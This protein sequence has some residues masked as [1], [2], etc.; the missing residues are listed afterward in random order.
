MSEIFVVY[1]ELEDVDPV[2]WRKLEILA[3]ASF[4]D[5]HCAIQDV[6]PWENRHLH[7][8]RFPT[9]DAETQIGIPDPELEA[10]PDF[11][12]SWETLLEDWFPSLPTSC[13]YIYD[14]GDSWRHRIILQS[15][16]PASDGVEYPR[17]IDGQGAC[18]PEDVGGAHRFQE[19]LEA[20]ADPTHEDHESFL[21]WYGDLWDPDPFDPDSVEFVS[22][23][24]R[25][26][27]LGIG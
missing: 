17:C 12:G 15:K 23:E 6:M 8:F 13:T 11:V 26:L 16:T 21:D 4:W 7:E 19:F 9:G 3:S 1:V 27:T 20:M 25:L 18:P 24:Q 5:L 2:A 14:F 10:D 22:P